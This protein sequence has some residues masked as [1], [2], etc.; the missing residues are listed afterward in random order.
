MPVAVR[1]LAMRSVGMV[2]LSGFIA[3]SATMS[4][5]G[6][7]DAESL[8]PSEIGSGP[9]PVVQVQRKGTRNYDGAAAGALSVPSDKES[10]VGPESSSLDQCMATWDAG[11][12]ITKTKWREICQRQIRDRDAGSDAQ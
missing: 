6:L 8:K 2:L 1:G 9:G 3:V 7:A 11:T 5:A 4:T 10:A 12:H